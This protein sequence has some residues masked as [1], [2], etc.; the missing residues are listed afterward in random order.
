MNKI[1]HRQSAVKKSYS[2]LYERY[3][4]GWFFYEL[5]DIHC[6]I[7]GKTPPSAPH[8]KSPRMTTLLDTRSKSWTSSPSSPL[9]GGNFMQR[10]TQYSDKW[11]IHVVQNRLPLKKS[12]GITTLWW[13][14]EIGHST[15]RSGL[16]S[17]QSESESNDENGG[18][19]VRWSFPCLQY[20][21][22]M[23]AGF[24]AERRKRNVPREFH[25]VGAWKKFDGAT[26]YY[27]YGRG[28]GMTIH[29]GTLEFLWGGL[30]WAGPEIDFPFGFICG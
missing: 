8:K 29:R 1:D 17:P 16:M 23:R 12:E 7:S 25:K 3:G 24:R 5:V 11:T 22:R 26:A 27:F 19:K 4:R 15:V 6:L 13:L 28:R 10:D 20:E 2:S 14:H 21:V 9:S 30:G 18:M